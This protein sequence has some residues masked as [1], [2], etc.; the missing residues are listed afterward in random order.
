MLARVYRTFAI[1]AI[2]LY[3]L[4]PLQPARAQTT[5]A[6]TGK[7]PA[8][9]E[10]GQRV[11][12]CAHSFHAFVPPILSEMAKMA[13]ISDHRLVGASFIGGSRVIQHWNVPDEKNQA[14]E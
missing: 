12:T 8:A 11:F 3:L 1:S 9:I 2:A 7:P 10:K 4:L 5:N 14:K 6:G 13:G